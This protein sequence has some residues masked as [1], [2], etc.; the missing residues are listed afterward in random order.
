MKNLKKSLILFVVIISIL[1]IFLYIY[2]K[3]TYTV[4]E[5]SAMLNTTNFPNNIY[6]K[7]DTFAGNTDT[8][9][10]TKEFYIKDNFEYIYSLDGNNEEIYDLEN[11]KFINII[12]KDKVINLYNNIV[13]PNPNNDLKGNFFHSLLENKTYSNKGIYKYCGKTTINGKKCIKI[14]MTNDFKLYTEVKYYYID[15]E[16]TYIVKNEFYSEG[17]KIYSQILYYEENAVTDE[18]VQKF[19]INNY[20]NYEFFSY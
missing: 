16:T 20:P 2:Q 19:D 4:E 5:I 12:H 10:E 8:Y 7:V 15:L 9:S 18:D 14:S 6:I 3:S 1:I 13:A 11:Y 17:E